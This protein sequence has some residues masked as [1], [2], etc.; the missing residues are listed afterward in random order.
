[1]GP[2]TYYQH[3][4]KLYNQDN[5]GH[6]NF[7]RYVV[8]VFN[9]YLSICAGG[10]VEPMHTMLGDFLNQEVD[11]NGGWIVRDSNAPLYCAM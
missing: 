1:M 10:N 11:E 5:K 8:E 4:F 9:D 7:K 2:M 3:L 6:T